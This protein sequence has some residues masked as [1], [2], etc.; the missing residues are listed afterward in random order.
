MEFH[1]PQITWIVLAVLGLLINGANHGKPRDGEYN[2]FISIV[3]TGIM[4]WLLWSGGFF[5]GHA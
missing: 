5:G 3:V 4:A 1:W 2:G